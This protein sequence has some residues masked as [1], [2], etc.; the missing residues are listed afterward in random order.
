[1]KRVAEIE[2]P[3]LPRPDRAHRPQIV[4]HGGLIAEV[5]DKRVG[6]A[7]PPSVSTVHRCAESFSVVSQVTRG[8][9]SLNP[10]DFLL[11]RLRTHRHV[12]CVIRIDRHIEFG[13]ILLHEPF[14]N[15]VNHLVSLGWFQLGRRHHVAKTVGD[16]SE[17]AERI[18]SVLHGE[19]RKEPG[20]GIHWRSDSVL[21]MAGHAV[22][23]V[24]LLP[25]VEVG[26]V[27]VTFRKESEIPVVNVF[28]V[29]E[30]DQRFAEL[31][32]GEKLLYLIS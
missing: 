7:D 17:H 2:E 32:T 9:K 24:E 13:S 20:Q 30:S 18:S 23:L 5:D 1:M 26:F 14:T 4:S 11:R 3:S 31:L 12:R 10:Q 25:L 19:L 6:T 28:E 8:S 22:K 21:T 29:V 27:P 16:G 15:V